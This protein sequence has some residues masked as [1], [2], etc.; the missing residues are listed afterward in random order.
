M[1]YDWRRHN[2]DTTMAKISVKRRDENPRADGTAALYAV[3]YLDNSKIRIPVGLT[4]SAEEWDAEKQVVKGRSKEA[5]DKNL[6]ISNIVARI[7][8][9]FV[10]ARLQGEKLSKQKFLHLWQAKTEKLDFVEYARKRLNKLS[11]A[12][13][14]ETIRHHLCVFDKLDQYQKGLK[15]EDITTDWLRIYAAHLRDDCRNAPNTVAKNLSIIRIYT[16]SAIKEGLLNN[17]PFDGYRMPQAE[18]AIVYLNEEELNTLSALYRRK[19]LDDLEQTV[20]RFFLF[21]TFTAMHISDARALHIEQIFGNEIHYKRKKTGTKVD[22]P[23]ST[24]AA[25]LVDFYKGG[26]H[27]GLLIENLPSDQGF[28]RILK[29]ICINAGITKNVSAKTGRHTFATLYYKKNAGDIGT[30]SKLLGH[31]KIST[32]M[33]YAH[34]MKDSRIAGVAAFDDIL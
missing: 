8:D 24:S 6:I 13:A 17:N 14:Y 1:S 30:L 23:L 21:M 18:P 29:R 15:F 20:L 19:T 27:R 34:I 9:I 33:I 12:L 22:M 11:K 32:T 25:K 4:V 5:H 31:T 2:S 10:R 3:F 7:S 28:N 16:N 26:R